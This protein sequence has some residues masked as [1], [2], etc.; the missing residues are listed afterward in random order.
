LVVFGETSI[1][2]C[3]DRITRKQRLRWAT[4]QTSTSGSYDGKH[5]I[6]SYTKGVPTTPQ[7]NSLNTRMKTPLAAAISYLIYKHIIFLRHEVICALPNATVFCT[8]MVTLK[9]I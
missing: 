5:N 4:P 9:T 1:S 7:H 8:V 3:N 6:G 2:A